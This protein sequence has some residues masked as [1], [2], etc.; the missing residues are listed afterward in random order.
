MDVMA[1]A[2]NPTRRPSP[3]FC[4]HGLL[5]YPLPS[6]LGVPACGRSHAVSSRR[7]RHFITPPSS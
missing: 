2:S 4:I 7:L 3:G 1:L 5:Q 6:S